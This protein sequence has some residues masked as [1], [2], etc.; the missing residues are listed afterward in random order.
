[1]QNADLELRSVMQRF[2]QLRYDGDPLPTTG[3]W[4]LVV[5]AMM[6]FSS[7]HGV[8]EDEWAHL[9]TEHAEERLRAW[10]TRGRRASFIHPPDWD[11]FLSVA[12]YLG[13]SLESHMMGPRPLGEIDPPAHGDEIFANNLLLHQPIGGVFNLSIG[14]SR[15]A[16]ANWILNRTRADTADW[17]GPE[18]YAILVGGPGGTAESHLLGAEIMTTLHGR[19]G[20]TR[21]WLPHLQRAVT[22]F[23]SRT[24]EFHSLIAIG[25]DS[26]SLQEQ[27]DIFRDWFF[28]LFTDPEDILNDVRDVYA[29]VEGQFDERPSRLYIRDYRV[30]DSDDQKYGENDDQAS[31]DEDV[32]MSDAGE[33]G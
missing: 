26:H 8:T 28:R 2:V 11:R 21:L 3:Q 5:N 30:Q 4:L 17:S 24:S 7:A 22:F 31:S 1:M 15:H 13:D 27:D 18:N 25:G 12:H 23:G 29:R 19:S 9:L 14:E 10:E 6:A 20:R 16:A 33:E 32:Q